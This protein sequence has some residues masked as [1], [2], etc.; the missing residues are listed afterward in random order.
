MNSQFE[1]IGKRI[2]Q[3][4]SMSK[5]TG[6]AAYIADMALPGMLHAKFLRSPY[7]HARVV[8]IDTGKAERL[9]GVKLVLTPDD[10]IS[11]TNPI[12]PTA[13]KQQY[14]L[15]REVKYVGDEVAAVAAVDEETAEE[16][17]ALIEVEYE[18]LPPVLDPEEA[19]APGAPQLHGETRNIREPQKVRIGNVDDG[20]KESEHV[21]KG[22]FSTPKQA[23]ACM[24]THGCLSSYDSVTGKLTHWTP[25]QSI[26]YTR[27]A[28]AE[29][30]NMPL[31]KVRIVAP[32]AIGGGFGSKARTFAY[33]IAAG[34]MSKMLG[35]PVKMVLSR[36]E[37]FMATRSRHP[38][39]VEEELGLKEDGTIVALRQRAIMDVGGYSDTAPLVAQCGQGMVPGPYKIP[40][41]WVDTY[42]V[43]TN[44]S[45]SGSFRGF[46]NPQVTFAR[47]SL[48]DIAAQ[49]MGIDPLELRLKNTIKPGE[50]PYT[51]STGLI[52]R[53]CGMEEC[54]HR[55]AEAIGWKEKRKSCTGIGL[56]CVI[57]WGGVK[58]RAV[59]AEFASAEVEVAPDGSLLVRT[60]NSDI[61]QGLYTVLAQI[62][63]E[64][65][66]IPLEKV[67]I[68]GADSDS[69]PP[70]FGC[71]GSKSAITTGSAVKMAAAEAKQKLFKVAGNMLEVDPGDLE[72]RAGKIYVRD[73]SRSVTIK[74]VAGAAYFSAVGGAAGPVFGRG[75]WSSPS[76]PQNEDGY[77]NYCNAYAFAATAVEVEVDPETGR[78]KITKFVSA[79]DVGRALNLNIVEGQIHGAAA[80]GIGL[81]MIEESIAYN[82]HSGNVRNPSFLEYRVPT[83]LD[84][85]DIQP[86]LIEAI[87]PE[88]PLGNKGAGETALVGAAPAIANA[89][90]DAI[91]VRITDLPITPAKILRA[92]KEKRDDS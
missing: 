40:N 23:H 66:G 36:E 59:N 12:G 10:V 70:D 42:P 80:M 33:D 79:D 90:F 13:P 62:A 3:L 74:E 30:L 78:V 4:D 11:K 58:I 77:G 20:F 48:L 49:K 17:L 37:E 54:L 86:V 26:L 73:M 56:A 53:S 31:N 91:G 38:Y 55:V 69:T 76:V 52:V 34:L 15:H 75:V 88:I 28:M 82:D 25:A 1:I 68:I 9:P 45:I 43:Y 92:L 65:L 2:P 72:A 71:F 7:A 63:A 39:I 27:M 18:L 47:E 81:G 60:G 87:D 83:A 22:R 14:A 29:A 51:T 44:K 84:L 46:G 50:L 6:T 5:V 24:D 64:E 8:R 16:A 67:T 85:P 41:I 19:M 61:G 57:N 21:F 32:P 89:I 35:R